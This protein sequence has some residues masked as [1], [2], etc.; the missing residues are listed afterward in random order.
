[1]CCEADLVRGW[2]TCHLQLITVNILE[3]SWPV[4][5]VELWESEPFHMSVF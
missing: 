1:M 4:D 3:P 5:I 2:S